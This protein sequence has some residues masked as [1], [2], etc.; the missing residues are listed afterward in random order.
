MPVAKR[1]TW[2]KTAAAQIE[3]KISAKS[4]LYFFCGQTYLEFLIELLRKRKMRMP[5]SGLSLGR[6]LQWYKRRL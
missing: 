4:E 5:L 6:R 2:A 3:H 1:K